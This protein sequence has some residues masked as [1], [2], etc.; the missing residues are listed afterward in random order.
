M[1]TD[2]N[3]EE[4][5]EINGTEKLSCDEC[6]KTFANIYSLNKHRKTIHFGVKSKCDLCSY[7]TNKP[8]DLKIH[9]QRMHEVCTCFAVNFS[10][11]KKRIIIK[12]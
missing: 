3:D 5:N 9:R 4:I 11:S 12:A 8:Y 1:G 6:K 10:T 2:E 7:E